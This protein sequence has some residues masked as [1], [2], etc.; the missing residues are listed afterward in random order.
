MTTEPRE[1]STEQPGATEPQG[2]GQ[3]ETTIHEAELASGPSGAVEWS[4]EL[5]FDEAVN[6]RKNEK[7]I[8][9]RGKDE[10][11]NRRLAGKVEAT[12]GPASRPQF[13]HT[14][15]AGRHALPHFHQ[16]SRSP[17][18]H[19]FYETRHLKARKPR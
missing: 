14:N 8:V 19:S 9:V 18:G 12:V 11:A 10:T 15:T 1:T 16:R 6:R 17:A 7:D 3:R 13:P 2:T 5:T 4:K